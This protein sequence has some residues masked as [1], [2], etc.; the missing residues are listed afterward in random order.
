MKDCCSIAAICMETGKLLALVICK[1]MSLDEFDW[2]LWKILPTISKDLE[3]YFTIQYD[4]V[5]ISELSKGNCF[6]IF[7]IVVSDELNERF[8]DK[9]YEVE[10]LKQ[11]YKIAYSLKTDI[12]SYTCFR[13]IES[14]NAKNSCMHVSFVR[15][16][17]Y[18]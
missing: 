4:I 7:D 9:S 16:H 18:L 10:L 12:L 5:K 13:K 1:V 11:A 6:H 15:A 8:P 14:E 3:K 17:K 2:T